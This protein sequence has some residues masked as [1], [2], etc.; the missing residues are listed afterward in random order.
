MHAVSAIGTGNAVPVF[1]G[2]IGRRTV[3]R[4]QD[5]CDE[6]EEVTETAFTQSTGNGL[7]SIPLAEPFILQV[8][9]DGLFRTGCR[10]RFQ[11]DDSITVTA[12]GI[13]HRFQ[14]TEIQT[15]IKGT[16]INSLQAD[17]FCP[18]GD[19]VVPQVEFDRF[20]FFEERLQFV[21]QQGKRGERPLIQLT[22]QSLRLTGKDWDQLFDFL[23]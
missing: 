15:D 4:P 19:K 12:L 16:E 22:G 17:R 6:R 21:V 14:F 11:R 3:V 1:Q 13:G 9:V 8:R 18:N 10:V 5:I 2:H 7:F 20:K 23:G